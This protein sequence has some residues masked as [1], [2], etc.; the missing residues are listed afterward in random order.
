[1]PDRPIQQPEAL[2]QFAGTAGDESRRADPAGEQGQQ[3]AAPEAP[4]DASLD[5]RTGRPPLPI[6]ALRLNR[7]KELGT[8]HAGQPAEREA[9][10]EDGEEAA[11]DSGEAGETDEA[12]ESEIEVELDDEPQEDPEDDQ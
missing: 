12:D 5:P 3:A 9:A 1:M 10:E 8:L 11:A 4:Y 2:A 6:E 7:E